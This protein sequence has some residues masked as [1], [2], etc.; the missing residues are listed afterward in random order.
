M[1]SCR[2]ARDAQ[3]AFWSFSCLLIG[4]LG[5]PSTQPSPL[6]E[7]SA[8]IVQRNPGEPGRLVSTGPSSM[9]IEC[10]GQGSPTVVFEAGLG[11]NSR[12]WEGVITDVRRQTRACRYDRLGT[13]RSDAAARPH[14]PVDMALEL[15]EL[16]AASGERP[17]LVLVGHS[18]GGINAR[19]FVQSNP[20]AVVG[21]VLVESMHEDQDQRVGALAPEVVQQEPRPELEA[22]REGLTSE[23]LNDGLAALRRGQRSLG[24]RPLVVLSAGLPPRA[25]ARVDEQTAQRMWAERRAMQAELTRLSSNSVQVIAEHSGHAVLRDQPQ[26]V[27]AAT[28]EVVRAVR[29]GQ[30]VQSERV[31]AGAAGAGP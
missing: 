31:L 19:L 3:H 21:L 15:G 7:Q 4:L 5:C 6:Q 30:R 12:N 14:S 13:G 18:L 29:Q 11:G 2:L 27:V 25:P 24:S 9:Y 20:S 16:L 17:P 26:L 1:S 22:N 28:L 23:S 8:P 10:A